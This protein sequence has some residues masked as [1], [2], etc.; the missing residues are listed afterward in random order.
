[1]YR[2][3]CTTQCMCLCSVYNS[4]YGLYTAQ[5]TAL[6]NTYYFIRLPVL[7]IRCEFICRKTRLFVCHTV[8]YK[9]YNY[10]IDESAATLRV[11]FRVMAAAAVA[12]AV[13]VFTHR[14]ANNE[15]ERFNIFQN[16]CKKKTSWI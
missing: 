8:H 11:F 9:T 13:A 14:C 1:M 16:I 6:Y 5:Q 3:V 10:F 15:N 12:T 2:C 4:V 7:I